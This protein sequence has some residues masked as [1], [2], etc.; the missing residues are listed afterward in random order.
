MSGD[1]PSKKLCFVIG[2]IG[3][4]G[5]DARRHADWLLK[6]IIEPVFV[7]HFSDFKVE[8]ADQI[9]APGSITSQVINRLLE[10]PLVIA[11]MSLH[12]DNAFYEL[13]IRHMM[14]NLPTI[15]M[16][17]SS[18]EKIP[19]DVAGL[20]TI[21]FSYAEHAHLET[22]KIELKNAT[23]EAIKPG[24]VVENPVTHA[25]GRLELQQHAKPAEKVLADE[26][27]AIRSRLD[28][29][30]SP[31]PNAYWLSDVGLIRTAGQAAIPSNVFHRVWKRMVATAPTTDKALDTFLAILK[32]E[33]PPWQVERFISS[34]E[35]FSP[36]K[37]A[38]DPAVAS[39]SARLP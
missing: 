7:Q 9:A 4:Q 11:D 10:A 16:I 17:L 15:H 1:Q 33:A 20:R 19:F 39:R 3:D 22:A 14:T 2:P 8:R 21:K 27:E 24:F 35:G 34:L 25:K 38:S 28:V 31:P 30:E 18:S 37:V 13:G 5:T 12:N 29:L 6:G 32:E 26:M 36:D 23:D